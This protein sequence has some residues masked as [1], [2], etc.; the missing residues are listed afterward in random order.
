[1]Q[2]SLIDVIVPAAGVGRRMG[3]NIPKQYALIHSKTVLEHSVNA[4]LRCSRVGSVIV[5][6]SDT[7]EYFDTLSFDT[8]RVIRGPGGSER[9]DTV[10]L[11]L[12]LA[13]TEYVMVHDAA[14]PLI[15]LEDLNSLANK[16]DGK[17]C[18]AILAS[19]VADTIKQV[20]DGRITRTVP[21][22]DLYRAYTPQ[23][24]R[25]VLLQEAL[26]LAAQKQLAVTDDA[27]ALELMGIEVEI[28][29]GRADNFKLTTQE[30]LMMAK[31]LIK[32]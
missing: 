21:R 22:H 18:G 23:L 10:R 1:M 26:N 9:S 4:L 3:L 11:C 32:E 24:C 27:S 28:V 8:D 30:D 16:A 5:G 20:S 29:E 6:V 12:S 14:R 7:D 13:K 19:R 31:L 2:S 17:V 15:C 25:R